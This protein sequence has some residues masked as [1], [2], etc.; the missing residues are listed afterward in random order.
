MSKIVT[1]APFHEVLDDSAALGPFFDGASWSGW[2]TIAK[3]A[4]GAPL[5]AEEEAFF[6]SVAERDPPKKKVRE[7]YLIVGR[8][9]GKDSF[10]SGLA[11]WYAGCVDYSAVTR[12][13]EKM[14]VMCLACD[15]TQA[16]IVTNYTRGYFHRVPLLGGIVENDVADG[17]DLR[18]GNEVRVFTNNIAAT[19]GKACSLV[20]LDEVAFFSEDGGSSGKEIYTAV[21]PS[22]ISSDGMLVAISTPYRKSGLLFEKFTK[23][24][25]KNS[26]DVL[27]IRGASR[28]F[29]PGL[30]ESF[31]AEQ[32][33]EDFEAASAEW[34]A[35]FRSDIGSLVDPALVSRLVAHGRHEIPPMAGVAYYA[36]TD[37]SGGSADSFTLAIC[38]REDER[39]V[40]DL[41]R[42]TQPPFSPESVI[43]EYCQVL[44]RYGISE[45]CGDRYAGLFPQ[46]Q[47]SKRGVNYVTSERNRS[48]IYLEMLAVINSGRV[49][50]L[51]HPKTISQLCALERRTSR[52][53]KDSVNHPPGGHDDLINSVAGAVVNCVGTLDGLSAWLELGRQAEAEERAVAAKW[54]R[55]AEVPPPAPN[56][57]WDVAARK[58]HHGEPPAGT[59]R[60]RVTGAF[61]LKLSTFGQ[62]IQ[63]VAGLN[64]VDP[65]LLE[66]DWLQNNIKAGNVTV[67]KQETT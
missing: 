52:A 27:V 35:V 16:K 44:K 28:T 56:G 24:Y 17:F 11:A 34:N 20:I 5:N 58:F 63:F 30:S 64:D 25:G 60:C 36:F 7:L 67:L 62:P 38:H 45:V 8:R 53:G 19:R 49:E 9:G 50:F 12:P 29:N 18:N 55:A 46:E 51:D 21:M 39:A 32:L 1:Y 61:G 14:T 26:K 59:V 15:R 33:A 40:L 43:E 48:E 3:A 57:F 65:K 42:E 2:K 4:F 6:R 10:A 37:P 13:G 41:I 22:L 47:F 66:H 54:Q 23:H 31:I